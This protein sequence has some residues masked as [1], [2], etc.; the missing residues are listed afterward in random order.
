M[1]LYVSEFGF[2]F[3]FVISGGANN[4]AQGGRTEDQQVQTEAGPKRQFQGEGNRQPCRQG[5]FILYFN[6]SQN[7]IGRD[8]Y[9]YLPRTKRCKCNG[10]APQTTKYICQCQYVAI[11]L[12]I[13]LHYKIDIYHAI[14]IRCAILQCTL[15]DTTCGIKH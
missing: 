6:A 3:P 9:F 4:E 11:V 12:S 8:I 14:A 13:V 10:L 2:C 7:R 1:K 15:N 5:Q